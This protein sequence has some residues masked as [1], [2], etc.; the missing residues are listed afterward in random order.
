MLISGNIPV[1]SD[2]QRQKSIITIALLVKADI[3][4]TKV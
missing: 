4:V 3:F 2:Q 1:L